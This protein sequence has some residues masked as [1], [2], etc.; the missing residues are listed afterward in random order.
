M[1]GIIDYY[2]KPKN[3]ATLLVVFIAVML[4]ILFIDLQFRPYPPMLTFLD[5]LEDP[6]DG[7]VQFNA[8][9]QGNTNHGIFRG[10]PHAICAEPGKITLIAGTEVYEWETNPTDCDSNHLILKVRSDD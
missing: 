4:I 6:I 9:V 3:A 5:P 1:S 10:V 2:K 8:R 7:E